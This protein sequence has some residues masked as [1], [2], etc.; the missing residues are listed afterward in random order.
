MLDSVILTGAGV[1]AD[2]T[3]SAFRLAAVKWMSIFTDSLSSPLST[4]PFASQDVHLSRNR[5]KMRRIHA[6]PNSA[7]VVKLKTFGDWASEQCICD[8]VWPFG[9]SINLK[10][11]VSITSQARCPEPTLAALVNLRPESFFQVRLRSPHEFTPRGVVR[12]AVSA[13]PSLSIVSGKVR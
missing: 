2:A 5:F 9:L 12:G 10:P 13:V 4:N 3:S 7:Q 8:S 6:T 11:T 1:I